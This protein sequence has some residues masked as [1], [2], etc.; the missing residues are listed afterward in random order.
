M[1]GKVEQRLKKSQYRIRGHGTL[2]P[3]NTEIPI[4][5]V[6]PDELDDEDCQASAYKILAPTAVTES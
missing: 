2:N 3:L 1:E 5:Q 6:E 4:T